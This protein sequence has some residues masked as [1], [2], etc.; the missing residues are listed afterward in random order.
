[1]AR[2][3]NRYSQLVTVLKVALP[4][5]ALVLLSVMF[6][7]SRGREPGGG[8]PYGEADLEALAQGP[9]VTAPEYAGVTSDGAVL[10]VSAERARPGPDAAGRPG[11][12]ATGEGV[13]LLLISPEG[14]RSDLS[15]REVRI[16]KAAS[17]LLMSG[18]VVLR[19]S[20][21]Y[22]IRSAAISAALDRTL[23]VS[24]GAVTAEAPAGRIEAGSMRIERAAADAPHVLVFKDGVKLVYEPPDE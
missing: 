2:L 8:L 24:P 11:G 21:A 3:D 13:R 14:L 19:H 5:A 6:L 18:D 16:D 4:L 10:T 15:A 1:M 7:L 12:S 22:E 20:G 23:F 17:V 9:R